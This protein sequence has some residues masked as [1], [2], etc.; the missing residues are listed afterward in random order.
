MI[1]T[2]GQLP[3]DPQNGAMPE[4]IELQT[5]QS[6]LNIKAILETAGATMAQIVKTT[7][8]LS[9]MN[10]FTKMNQV[11]NTFFSKGQYPARSAV[12]VAGLPKDAMVEIE[13]IACM[14]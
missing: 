8:F 7:V 13:A 12:E 10:N 3:I 9:D 1:F 14:R 6:L 11:Y 5:R 2:S 4:G